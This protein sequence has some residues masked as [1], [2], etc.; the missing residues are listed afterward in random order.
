MNNQWRTEGTLGAWEWGCGA[1][2][3]S[4]IKFRLDKQNNNI[5]L[6]Y[7][8]LALAYL[9]KPSLCTSIAPCTSGTLR[10]VSDGGSYFRPYGRPEVCVNGGW[11]TI[12][13]DFW[14]DRDASVVCRQLGYSPYGMIVLFTQVT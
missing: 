12:C 4:H 13:D 1:C 7:M 5:V 9:N 2:M 6:L 14:D 11:G 10:L 3:P 8:G